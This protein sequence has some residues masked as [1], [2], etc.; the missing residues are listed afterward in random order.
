MKRI[1]LGPDRRHRIINAACVVAL[2]AIGL[3]VWS[4]LD[5]RPIAVIVAMS[6]GQVFG[7]LSLVGFLAA[8]ASDLRKTLERPEE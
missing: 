4:L 2:I 8:A 6:V 1:T 3:M 5:P 7:T